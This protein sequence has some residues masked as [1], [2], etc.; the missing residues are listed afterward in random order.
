M[1]QQAQLLLRLNIS[2]MS[3]SHTLPKVDAHLILSHQHSL[4]GLV[5]K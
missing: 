4:Q 3:T 1:G 2:A 5:H